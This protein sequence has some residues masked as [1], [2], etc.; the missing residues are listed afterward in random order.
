MKFAEQAGTRVEPTP[1]S[2]AT[3]P[4]CGA[5]VLAKCGTQRVWHW[6]HKSTRHCDSWWEPETDWHRK[7]KELF[8]TE[9]QE[10]GRR[11]DNGEL[12]IADVLTPQGLALEFQ[13]SYIKREEIEIRTNFHKNICWIVDGTRLDSTLTQFV[14][15]LEMGRPVGSRGTEV[16]QAYLTHSRF[17]KQWAGLSAPVVV[18]FGGEKIW[19]IGNSLETSVLVYPLKKETLVKQFELGNRPPQVQIEQRR[20]QYVPLVRSARVPGRRM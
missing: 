3:C 17:L 7:W 12:H 15:A 4:F 8:P 11:D 20:T 18:D 9:W 13:H 5:E 14:K 10:V 19:V 1:K 2:R 16:Y 6:A